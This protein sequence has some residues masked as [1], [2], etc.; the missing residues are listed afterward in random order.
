MYT[1]KINGVGNIVYKSR[2]TR[3]PATFKKVPKDDLTMLKVMC[4]SLNATMEVLEEESDRLASVVQ[5][6]QNDEV[7]ISDDLGI[8]ETE[9]SI[10]ELFDSDD[11]LG[12]IIDQLRKEK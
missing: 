1:V 12:N 5:K 10:E 11:A 9:T 8:E 3:L 2:E 7:T 4:K 6:V